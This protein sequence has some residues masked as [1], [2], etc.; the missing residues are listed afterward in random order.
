[1]INPITAVKALWT[2]NKEMKKMNASELKTSEG[3]LTLLLNIITIVSAVWGL[4]PPVLVAKIAAFSVAA[5]GIARALVKA[6]TVIAKITPSPK[7]DAAVAEAGKILDVIG[8]KTGLS[9]DEAG[10]GKPPA[11]PQP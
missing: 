4:L 10:A 7:D 11:A 8:D 1:M 3:R 9:A 6:A 2:V 5:Y